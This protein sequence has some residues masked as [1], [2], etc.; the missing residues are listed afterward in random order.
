MFPLSNFRNSPSFMRPN[1]F[2]IIL[3]FFVWDYSFL[4]YLRKLIVYFEIDLSA[5]L[6]Q[7]VSS[8]K[9][10][11]RNSEACFSV[12]AFNYDKEASNNCEVQLHKA[13]TYLVLCIMPL[14]RTYMKVARHDV[15]DSLCR[16][17]CDFNVRNIT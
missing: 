6:T 7:H 4:H 8:Q 12:H 2:E 10:V 14:V 13:L 11:L 17:Y 9:V 1:L 5:M 15:T 3:Y 16:Y